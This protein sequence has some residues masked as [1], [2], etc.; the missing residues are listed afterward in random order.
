MA[1]R[2]PHPG[3]LQQASRHAAPRKHRPDTTMFSLLPAGSL[4][5]CSA[6]PLSCSRHPLLP[7]RSAAALL[8][9]LLF[10]APPPSSPQQLGTLHC[11][12]CI[13]PATRNGSRSGS[14]LPHRGVATRAMSGSGVAGG[15]RPRTV[16]VCPLCGQRHSKWQGTYRCSRTTAH[17]LSAR[18]LQEHRSAVACSWGP[19]RA[20]P[21]AHTGATG[22]FTRRQV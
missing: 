15:G 19:R 21:S 11:C 5:R 6:R 16:F 7:A 12:A 8:R 13:S 9:A 20:Q 4:P 1:T 18:R 2:G 10:A 22:T 3:S 14:G 17:S